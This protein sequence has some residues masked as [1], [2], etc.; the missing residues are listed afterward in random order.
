[1]EI[2]FSDL[3]SWLQIPALA[4]LQ[5]LAT[6]LTLGSLLDALIPQYQILAH[7]PQGEFHHDLV[8]RVPAPPP[9]LPGPILVISSDCNGGVKELFCF[10]EVPSRWGLWHHRCPDN[11]DFVGDLPP[12][13]AQIRTRLWFDPCTLL[14]PDAPSEIKP[15]FRARQPG[16]GWELQH[17]DPVFFAT[18]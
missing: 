17:P 2:C 10:P 7:W 16:G 3:V 18:L 11:P 8:I 12:L 5:Q 6:H 9:A 15:E 13:L 1:M 4:M 14:G